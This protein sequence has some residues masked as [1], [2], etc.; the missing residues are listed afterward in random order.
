MAATV[1]S[2]TAPAAIPSSF[3]LQS[4]KQENV[5]ALV[6]DSSITLSCS[7]AADVR[8]ISKAL[9]EPEYIEAW[10]CFPNLGSDAHVEVSQKKDIFQIDCYCAGHLQAHISSAFL[11]RQ[12]REMLFS[13]EKN[14]QGSRSKSFVNIRLRTGSGT[15]LLELRHIGFASSEELAWHEALWRASL[16]KL[17]FLLGASPR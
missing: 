14:S 7:I 13:W 5:E 9:T 2:S 16:L 8:R 6:A 12:E 3:E 10:I 1:V 15:N 4:R 11:I 17:A